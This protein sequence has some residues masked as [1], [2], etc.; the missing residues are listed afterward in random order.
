MSP[1]PVG[2]WTLPTEGCSMPPIVLESLL[3]A[4]WLVFLLILLVVLL[5]VVIVLVRLM[6]VATVALQV[7]AESHGAEERHYWWPVRQRQRAP[8][9]PRTPREP[10]APRRAPEPVASLRPAP[11]RSAEPARPEPARE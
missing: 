9:E 5:V 7:W 1:G 11:T 6:L 3:T 4:M 8:R 2:C 10:A